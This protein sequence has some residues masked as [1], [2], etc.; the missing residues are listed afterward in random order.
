MKL[1]SA[2]VLLVACTFAGLATLQGQAPA[3]PAAP[4]DE[5]A[6][7]RRQAE[8]RALTNAKL[9]GEQFS[10]ALDVIAKEAGAAGDYDQALAAQRRREQIL[11]LYTKSLG[12]APQANVIVLKPADA[13]INGSVN[14][15]RTMDA[16]VT[17]RT[18]G[19]IATWDVPK[20]TPGSYEIIV[21]YAVGDMGEP[22]RINAFA[23]PPDTTTGGDFEFYEDSSL[24]GASQNKRTG[25]VE[26]TGG[27][28]QWTT[29]TLPPVQIT[30]ASG[31]FALKITRAK[32]AGGVMNVKE[33]R[34]APPGTSTPPADPAGPAAKVDEFAELEKAHV[35]RMKGLITPV[36]TAY[37]TS[38]TS[39]A[40]KAMAAGDEDAADD[41]S[42]EAKRAATTAN[43]DPRTIL[44]G[45]AKGSKPGNPVEGMRELKGATYVEDDQ[46]SGDRF[47]V[48][49]NGEQFFVRLLW[50]NCPPR[51]A[52][53]T[54]LLKQ[55]T[56]YFGITPEDA[57][58][59]AK[60]AK[61]FTKDF[62]EGK[63][64][65]LYTRGPRDAPYG[66]FAAVRPEGVGDFAGVL[67]DNG[68]AFVHAPLA[69]KTPA[70][71]NEDSILSA[72]KEREAAARKRTIV[73][74]AWALRNEEPP[75]AKP[76]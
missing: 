25:T 73:P 33:V 74:G 2:I 6:L 66:V 62:L 59:I 57:V 50:V 69:K 19:S 28:D 21:T 47:L 67:V 26:T 34:L 75:T 40:E 29:V 32:G 45:S 4:A 14:H 27:W 54:K 39:L 17:W 42:D 71:Q 68:L 61:T 46:N 72:L 37:T 16:L 30:R 76:E 49:H 15:D 58:A 38:L 41:F 5:L 1:R 18:V 36:V 48:S 60:Q 55:S 11:S 10:N 51:D 3:D 64:L 8:L 65:T 9:L 22:G 23:P 20:I 43:V 31:R 35:E 7:L 44:S 63:S 52:E 70:R 24:P 12:D 53:D 13:R 56:D